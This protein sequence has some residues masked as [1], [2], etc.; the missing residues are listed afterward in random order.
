M[1]RTIRRLW[2]GLFLALFVLLTIVVYATRPSQLPLTAPVTLVASGSSTIDPIEVNGPIFVDWPKPDLALVFTGELDGYMEPCGCSGLENQK[3]GLK[4]RMAMIEGLKKQGWPVALFDVGG[5]TKRLG[6]QA[7]IKFRFVAAGL[8]QM[9]Y[10]AIG[11]GPQELQLNADAVAFALANLDPE[12]NPF[13]AAN[14]GIYGFDSG[15]TADYRV[16]EAGGKR[17]G[18]TSVLGAKHCEEIAKS[19]DIEVKEPGQALVEVSPKL[20]AENCDLQVLLVHGTPQEARELAVQFP[21]FQYVATAG[22]AEEP[23]ALPGKIDGS[24]AMLIDAG[25][26]GMY[27]VVVGLYFNDAQTPMR[28]Q[29]VPLDVRFSD[30]PEMQQKMVDYQEELKLLT[31]A[32]LGLKGTPHPDGEFIGSA[33]CADCHTEATEVFE[34]TPHAHALDTLRNLDPPRHFDP[35]CVS[36]HV[37]GWNPQKYYPY[38]SGYFGVEETP[39]MFHQGCENC[40]GPGAAHVAA[41]SGDVDATE[42]Q[43][44]K[45]REDMRLRLVDNEGN[46]EG[47][48][49]GPVVKNCMECHDL[50]NSPDFDF[51]E[52]WPEVEH[53]GVD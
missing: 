31:F 21:Q 37:V 29:R 26:K 18:V 33:A 16:I 32:G 27:A 43:I 7:E 14:V 46:M 45:L 9:G 34:E 38:S 10:S 52:Y 12:K 15:M 5:L 42:E 3:G 22:G 11:L 25:H 48:V 1:D 28:Y 40:H 2:G 41:E 39:Q 17:I 30:A 23:P 19:A 53:Y 47:Q 50:D 44:D 49:L 36:C 6:P 35:E 13:V 20:N 4:R 51:Q 8:V 24:T